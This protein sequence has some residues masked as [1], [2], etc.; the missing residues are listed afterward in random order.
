ME[1]TIDFAKVLKIAR[2]EKQQASIEIET[3]GI[4]P[5]LQLS[6]KRL[7]QRLVETEDIQTL[8]CQSGCDWCCHFSVD[9][10]PVE[11]LNILQYLK[12]QFSPQ[13]LLDLR[14]ELTSN[15]HILSQLNDM[16][17]MHQ[18]IKCPLLMEKKCAIYPARPQTCRNYHATDS[19]GC[20]Q[21]FEEPE[22]EDIPPEFA[23]GVYQ[24]GVSHV[25]AF[26]KTMEEAGYDCDAYELNSALTELLENPDAVQKRFEAKLPAFVGI[27]GTRV[28]YEL[29]EEEDE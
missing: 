18:T 12:Q 5:A 8:A 4:L 2:E 17:R 29:T 3:L 25:E 14:R 27:Q 6:L 22:N 26:S 11:A 20:R 13:Q 28:G 23:A 1:F 7:D 10:R 15:S 9:I 16:E 24:A 19:A 21:S